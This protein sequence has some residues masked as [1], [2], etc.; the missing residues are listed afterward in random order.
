MLAAGDASDDGPKAADQAV[1]F[2]RRFQL[3]L[4]EYMRAKDSLDLLPTELAKTCAQV[5]DVDGAGLSLFGA[6]FRVPLGASS[7]QASATERLQFTVGVGPC[8][9]AMAEHNEVRVSE[10]DIA[11]R[12][13]AFY[14]DLVA[15]TPYR[16][17][18]AL[19]IQITADIAGAIDLYFTDATAALTTDLGRA[20]QAADHIAGALRAAA[21]ITIPAMSARDAL[22]PTW[23]A[24][25]AATHRL[26]TWIAAGVV[27][28]ETGLA[29]A[30]ALSRLRAHAYA[31]D[32]DVDHVT[33]AILGGRLKLA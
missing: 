25:P 22:Q 4:A 8:I 24:A 5:L 15:R 17:I 21:M 27:V 31:N 13:P 11:R 2:G 18:A 9:E 33:D 29:A 6:K 23:M 28:S 1:A 20:A 12:W 16:S 30:D 3:T 26:R 7:E 10:A 32:E 19:P 14:D